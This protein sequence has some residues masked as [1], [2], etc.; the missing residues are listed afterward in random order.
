MAVVQRLIAMSA[1]RALM[2]GAPADVMADPVVQ[3]EYLG[4]EVVV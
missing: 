3:A 4:A 2:D 1:G